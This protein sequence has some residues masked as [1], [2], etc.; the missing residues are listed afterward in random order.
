MLDPV[1]WFS[2]PVTRTLVVSLIVQLLTLYGLTTDD[3]AKIAAN[4]W[5]YGTG[6]FGVLTTI[7][8]IVR[9]VKSPIQPVTLTKAGAE[10]LAESVDVKKQGGFIALRV[11][12]VLA[13]VSIGAAAGLLFGCTTTP[14]TV[15]SVACDSTQT[16]EVERCAKAVV[17]LYTTVYQQRALEAMQNPA[18]SDSQKETLGKAE[19][20]ASKAMLELNRANVSYVQL[21]GVLSRKPDPTASEQDQVLQQQAMV[22]DLLKLAVPKV[23]YLL[24]LIG[25]AK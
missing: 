24:S 19:D 4:V 5:L 18:L 20:S 12:L 15:L 6:L 1:P 21:K 14:V 23:N 16:Y 17:D 25:G 8:A 2:S 3:A 13:T 7:W 22:D 9:R 11:A 10:K